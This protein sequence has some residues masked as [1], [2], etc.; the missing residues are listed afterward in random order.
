MQL[1]TYKLRITARLKKHRLWCARL[2]LLA[3]TLSITNLQAAYAVDGKCG[4][5]NGATFTV[6]PTTNRCV[7]GAINLRN[8]HEVV[9]GWN[10]QCDG[11]G[12]GKIV[13]CHANR[14]ITT[15]TPTASLLGNPTSIR[16]GGESL[17][18]WS[19]TNADSCTGTGFSTG[20][21]KSGEVTVTPTVA[22]TYK[23]TCTA[24]AK[25]ATSSV[26]VNVLND[27]PRARVQVKNGTVVT[28]I[29]T[30]L[31]GA[32]LGSLGPTGKWHD[33][34]Y[35][36]Y[37]HKDLKLNA[38]RMDVKT[39]QIGKTVAEQLPY[40]DKAVDLAAENGMYAMFKT[41]IKPGDYDL[42]SLKA[43]WTVVAPRYKN[44]THVIYELTNEPVSGG[45]RWGDA[46]QWTDKVINDLSSVYNIMRSAAPQTHITLFSTPNLFPDCASYKAVIAKMKGVDWT[47]ASV[48]F[49]HYR[50]TTEFGET[51]LKCL[52]ASYPLL[53][54]ETNYWNPDA[55]DIDPHALRIYEKL[56]ISWFS[57]DGKGSALHL[58]NEILPD[59]HSHGY[60]WSFEP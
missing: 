23:V 34:A 32:A 57:L 44:R 50:G 48:S 40:L 53:M 6:A 1:N 45:P 2:L 38:V 42:P 59:L 31:R 58:Q 37:L 8:F 29:G 52:K 11:A 24:G 15:P 13:D 49:H 43:F 54:T 28:D 22:Q 5:A 16:I 56:G 35:W 20:G 27:G 46:K 19:S 14:P 41:S 21:K 47:K 3:T 30:M 36:Q 9:N 10:W 7:G 12:A 25:S 4:S 51:N 60:N 39:I 17:L 55:T 26:T 33:P 18:T